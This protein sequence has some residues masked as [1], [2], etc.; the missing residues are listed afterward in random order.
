MTPDD[1]PTVRQLVRDT[2]RGACVISKATTE[3]LEIVFMCTSGIYIVRP[4]DEKKHEGDLV[5]TRMID[6]KQRVS[7]NDDL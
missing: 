3:P 5:V 6:G 2:N 4:V 1:I 7:T